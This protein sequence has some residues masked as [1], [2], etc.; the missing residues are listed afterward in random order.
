M[1]DR[2]AYPTGSTTSRDNFIWALA[3]SRLQFWK[4]DA[5]VVMVLNGSGST[6]GMVE[7]LQLV[8]T[9]SALSIAQPNKMVLV[10]VR[11]P[12]RGPSGSGCALRNMALWWPS[13]LRAALT[14]HYLVGSAD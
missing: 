9:W 10:A 3:S 13:T 14:V 12:F 1:G 2:K 5:F 8:G 7:K 11:W 4:L 6:G